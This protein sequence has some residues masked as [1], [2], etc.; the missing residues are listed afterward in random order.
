MNWTGDFRNVS[1]IKKERKKKD[2]WKKLEE[3]WKEIHSE[4]LLKLNGSIPRL[5]LAFIFAQSYK[6]HRYIQFGKIFDIWTVWHILYVNIYIVLLSD[7][8]LIS[9]TIT[10]TKNWLR[11]RIS[12]SE[13]FLHCTPFV[14]KTKLSQ[15][16]F[17]LPKKF[18]NRLILRTR[19]C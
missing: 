6:I 8:L 10:Q 15:G 18:L 3:A 17:S 9:R 5:F 4:V 7:R 13:T 14:A 16:S 11:P 12:R 1:E 19:A 2:S